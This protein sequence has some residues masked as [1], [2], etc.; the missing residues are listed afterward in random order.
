MS[1]YSRLQTHWPDVIA[2][3]YDTTAKKLTEA[4]RDQFCCTTVSSKDG[5]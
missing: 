5:E 1:N 4:L 3:G 2:M